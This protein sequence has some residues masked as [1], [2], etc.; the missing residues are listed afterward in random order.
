MYTLEY[1]NLIFFNEKNHYFK[2]FIKKNEQI[3]FQ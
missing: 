1:N 2:N 3:P